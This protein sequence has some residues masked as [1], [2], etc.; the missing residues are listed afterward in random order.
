MRAGVR[1]SVP[2]GRW[3]GHC[4]ETIYVKGSAWPSW[5]P[6]GICIWSNPH[7]PKGL[8]DGWYS[9]GQIQVNKISV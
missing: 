8:D 5:G 1:T 4:G 9:C 3:Q 2:E 7:T 6:Q